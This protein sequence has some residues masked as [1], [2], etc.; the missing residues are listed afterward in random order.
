MSIKSQLVLTGL[1]VTFGIVTAC[2]NS[3]DSMMQ[4]GKGAV[5]FRLSSSASPTL[6]ATTHDGSSKDQQLQ[7][8]NVTFASI[9]ARNLDGQLI[10]VTIALPV[11]ADLLGLV[12]GGAITLPVGF[13]PPGTYDQ[14][15]IVMTK[16]EL[17]LANG[18]IVTIDPPGGGWTAI[19]NV[20]EP[21]TVVDGATTTVNIRFRAGGAFRWL[22]DHWDFHPNFD[23]DGGNDQGDEDDD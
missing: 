2:S 22:N 4:G 8:A 5:E 6:A 13:L 17:T 12:S 1:A 16:V 3:S 18:T 10:D 20:T 14:L 21:F 9:E 23:C 15:V 11:T 19:V 7:S